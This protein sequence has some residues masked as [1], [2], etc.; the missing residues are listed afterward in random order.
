MK[1]NT[2]DT[3]QLLAFAALARLGSFTR[4]AQ[5]L[6]LTQSAISHAIKA[7]E[8]QAGCRLFERAG[9]RVALTQS[10][11]QFLRHVDKILGEMKAAR[12]GLDELS[13][14][15]HG[16]LRLGASTTACQYILPTVLREFKQSFPKCVI[17][18]DP[19]DHARQVEQLLNNQ[20]DL[21]LMLE[22]QGQK[23]LNF[24]P[25]FADELRFLAAPG[26]PWARAGKVQREK[27]E[28]QTLILYNHTSYTFRLVQEYFRAEE[29]P[30]NNILE[31]G[32]MEAIKELVKIGLGVG[33]L[34]PWVAVTEISAGALVSLPLGKRKLRRQWGVGHLNGRR[35][36]LGE[37]TFVGL[38][39]TVTAELV[40]RGVSAVA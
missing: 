30:L 1:N 22:P 15:G 32:S 28:E 31:L 24:V 14:W 18:I 21:A 16:R 34:A 39:Q 35:L 8:E 17:T 19:G 6:Y 3:R 26:H 9:R 5:E 40:G 37:E 23:E 11:E 13:R 7:L 20:I 33:V 36:S 2:F 4:A 27:F 10:G 38:C 25:L 12:R 29:L